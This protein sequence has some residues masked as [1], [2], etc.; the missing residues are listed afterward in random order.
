M[1]T[2]SS[3]GVYYHYWN[4]PFLYITYHFGTPYTCDQPFKKYK[5][6]YLTERC[7]ATSLKASFL[8]TASAFIMKGKA[9]YK[10]KDSMSRETPPMADTHN[11]DS[12]SHR[13][14]AINRWGRCLISKSHA[15]TKFSRSCLIT[16]S[17]LTASNLKIIIIV[18]YSYSILMNP[19][20]IHQ[21]QIL[22]RPDSGIHYL[23]PAS[24]DSSMFFENVQYL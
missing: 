17:I 12:I 19:V 20:Q 23:K 6:L 24:I 10:P 4:S 16:A 5:R 2:Y 1:P 22:K 13:S 18:H 11:Y 3:M 14:R 7:L 15:H 9:I 8:E 21:F